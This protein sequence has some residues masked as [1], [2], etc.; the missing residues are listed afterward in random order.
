MLLRDNF[1]QHPRAHV[2][3]RLLHLSVPLAKYYVGCGNFLIMGQGH[4]HINQKF[5][6]IKIQNIVRIEIQSSTHVFRYIIH[7]LRV[8]VTTLFPIVTLYGMSAHMYV[9]GI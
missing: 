3:M 9:I 4:N 7:D 8:P 2:S 5:L 1:A 6:P